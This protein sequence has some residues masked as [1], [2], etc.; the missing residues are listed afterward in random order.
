MQ[1]GRAPERQFAYDTPPHLAIFVPLTCFFASG[2]PSMTPWSNQPKKKPP[3][4]GHSF[5][6][7][8]RG[9]RLQKALAEA[10][11]GSRR[12]CEEIIESGVVKVNGEI[13]A[14]L[15]AWV[16]PKRDHISVRGKNIKRD[17][18][19]VYV[20]LFKPRGVVCSN[21][22]PEGRTRAIDLVNHPSD[23][24]LYPV[25]RLDVESSGLLLL[26]NDG[27]LANRL[28]HPRYGVHKIYEVTVSG[29][30]D[31]SAVKKLERGIFLSDRRTSHGRKPGRKTSK[32]KLHLLKQDR[33]RT[34]LRME[35]REGRNRQI[36][37]MM[38]DVGHH[39]KKL[40]RIQ[41]G[42]LKLKGL[43]PNQWR[44]LLPQEIKAL[45]RAAYRVDEPAKK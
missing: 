3:S 45:Q 24:R 16:D 4:K 41:M 2:S 6:D 43:R 11:I 31:E 32:S 42:P 17:E 13:V 39:V 8:A 28:T 7:A 25:G 23:V 1:A 21:E 14:S 10:G 26:T 18:P 27:E 20:M 5:T 35:L 34:R 12:A 15:P 30:L 40:R 9:I 36:R 29:S 37:R 19:H 22:D 38:S 44:E 33:N